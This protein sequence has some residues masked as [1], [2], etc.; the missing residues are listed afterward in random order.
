MRTEISNPP[1]GMRVHSCVAV[2]AC[3]AGEQH[4]A[5][6]HLLSDLKRRT[7]SSGFVTIAG[8]AAKFFLT[9]G[10]TM[11]L[12]RLLTPRDFGLVAM[13]MTVMSFLRVFY[14]PG[15]SLATLTNVTIHH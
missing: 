5:T 4:F 9:L 7:I 15:L 2:S 8:Q 10:S 13:V 6:D 12:A 11:V 1:V 14:D 3:G